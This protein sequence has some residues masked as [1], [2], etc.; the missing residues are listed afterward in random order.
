[1]RVEYSLVILVFLS[2]CVSSLVLVGSI[3]SSS[4]AYPFF[5]DMENGEANWS[6]SDSWERTKQKPYRGDWAWSN[7]PNGEYNAAAALTMRINLEKAKFPILRFWS[8]LEEGA[9]GCVEAS[10]DGDENW[11]ILEEVISSSPSQWEKIEVE[12]SGY[13]EKSNLSIRFRLTANNSDSISGG[14]YIDDVNIEDRCVELH[15]YSLFTDDVECEPET[16][17]WTS[18]NTSGRKNWD[19]VTPGY[20]SDCAWTDSPI[21]DYEKKVKVTLTYK[22]ESLN[23]AVAPKLT[24]HHKY[25]TEEYGDICKVFIY[26]DKL[27]GEPNEEYSAREEWTREEL[28]I[29]EKL[30]QGDVRISFV[31]ESNGNEDVYDG[32]YIDDIQIIDEEI[33]ACD[34]EVK[35]D[36]SI[37]CPGETQTFTVYP[38][39]AVSWC[40]D[41]CEN[42]NVSENSVKELGTISDD[43]SY[44]APENVSTTQKVLIE[45]RSK[46][47]PQKSAY[48]TVT[49][50]KHGNSDLVDITQLLLII[51]GLEGTPSNGNPDIDGDGKL[52]IYDITAL[53][54]ELAGRDDT[55]A[56]PSFT[57]Q[58]VSL[59][60]MPVITE[61]GTTTLL[62]KIEDVFNLDTA[63]FQLS[64]NPGAVQM[65]DIKAGGLMS[66]STPIVNTDNNAGKCTVV[67][68]LPGLQGVSGSGTIA[69]VTCRKAGES[70]D[71]PS[72]SQLNLGNIYGESIPVNSAQLTTTLREFPHH[73]QLLQ[74][75]PNPFNP[76]TWIPYKL[77]QAADVTIWIY[78]ISGGLVQKLNLGSKAVGTYLKKEE[79]AHW[80]GKSCAG[81]EVASGIYFYV[82]RAGNF[83]AMRKM[84]IVR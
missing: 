11:E 51:A 3:Y 75:Y 22:L 41:S 74:N 4:S 77:S 32:W 54:L 47:D 58:T 23:G 27:P 45:A 26:K 83:T 1:M 48:A 7:R 56:T 71:N 82:L 12:L 60:L 20:N 65:I 69:Q 29:P 59:N 84:L 34:F 78:D 8:W 30:Y 14:W 21:G 17:S 72:V 9:S 70:L 36:N 62:L 37:L 6:S 25:S 46:A 28:D 68:N 35:P 81:E 50:L 61:Q 57:S 80:N 64:W 19:I 49:I 24:F 79:A 63:S 38:L 15:R 76:E 31:L 18:T 16:K 52:T 44:T 73:T 55:P 33:A 13:E 39:V 43:G 67:M 42:E 2:M 40:I 5:D 53:E 10:S 66:A